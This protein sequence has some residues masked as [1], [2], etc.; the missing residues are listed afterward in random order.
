MVSVEGESRIGVVILEPSATELLLGMAFLRQFA[1]AL[2]VSEG[3]VILTEEA[4]LA[5]AA[6]AHVVETTTDE[7]A[8]DPPPA[9]PFG[10]LA[11]RCQE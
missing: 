1:R 5:R 7:P 10:N 2:F 11:E 8:P 4:E 6:S 3:G 9:I